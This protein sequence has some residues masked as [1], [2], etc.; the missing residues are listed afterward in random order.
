M[1]TATPSTTYLLPLRR[2]RLLADLAAVEIVD[3]DA[4]DDPVARDVVDA[5]PEHIIRGD[6]DRIR[7]HADALGN[8]RSI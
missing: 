3:E 8:R 1:T 7:H 5:E 4:R 2:Q 6:E